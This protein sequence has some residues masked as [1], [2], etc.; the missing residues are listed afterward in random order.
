MDLD[1]SSYIVIDPFIDITRVRNMKTYRILE[2]DTNK[3][4]MTHIKAITNRV[5]NILYFLGNVRGVSA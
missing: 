4:L 5:G 1:T 3:S 2:Y